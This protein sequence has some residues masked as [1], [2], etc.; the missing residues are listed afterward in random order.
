MQNNQ[1]VIKFCLMIRHVPYYSFGSVFFPFLQLA[2]F[3][4]TVTMGNA[5]TWCSFSSSLLYFRF[6]N[7]ALFL[8]SLEADFS[9]A[10]MMDLCAVVQI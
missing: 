4:A 3:M 6:V 9:F 2:A 5:G 8:C 7:I 1:S 10:F